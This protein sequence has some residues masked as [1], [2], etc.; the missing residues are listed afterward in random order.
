M[1]TD[2]NR[3]SLRHFQCRDYLWET[4]EQM[5][6]ELECSVDYLINE[7]MRQYARSRRY[8]AAT[9]G[10]PTS[11]TIPPGRERDERD[12]IP[13]GP[14]PP[15]SSSV[16]RAPRT[17]LP[18]PAP[19]PRA[20]Q[21][22]SSGLPRSNA[23][24]SLPSTGHTAPPSKLP[25][26]PGLPP[27][28]S[29]S[30]P[31]LPAIRSPSSSQL[32][33]TARTTGTSTTHRP[34]SIGPP[35]LP[36]G[37]TGS[38]PAAGGP[39]PVPRSM[40]GSA[41]VL[42]AIYEGQRHPVTKEEFVIGRGQKTSDLV[43]RDSNVSRRHAVVVLHNGQYWMVDQQ[44]TNGVE[45]MGAKIDRKRIEEGDVFKICDYEITFSYR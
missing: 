15:G 30:N 10:P 14:S 45:F 16:G 31:S 8:S 2:P 9:P 17:P 38:H 36:S 7:A 44:S 18:P 35:P 6:G 39:P 26:L 28:K 11:A 24:P 20:P 37:T 40:P 43:I 21:S 25:A 12:V 4:F 34:G 5:S 3:K 41:P 13:P 33:A 29:G 22:S 42:Y 23:L 19:P 32:P 1:A 27:L